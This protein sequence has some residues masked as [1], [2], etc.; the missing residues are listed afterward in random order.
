MRAVY[1]VLKPGG[2]FGV[3]DHQGLEGRDNAALH[4]ML[5]EDAIR[6]AEAAGFVV[7]AD[8]GL[9]HHHSD[10]MTKHMRES[11]RG[12]TYRFVLRLRKP[13]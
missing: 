6:V 2:F 7:E 5:K 12:E 9:L 13:E 3:I 11:P 10:D 4:R 1:S 8:S